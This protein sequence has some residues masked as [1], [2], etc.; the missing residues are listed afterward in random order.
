MQLSLSQRG[1]TTIA[2]TAGAIDDS[3]R[4][5]F[6]E[7]LHPVIAQGSAGLILDLSGSNYVNSQGLGHLVTLGTHANTKGTALVLCGLMPHVAGVVS[8]TKL[9][10][11]F[12]IAPDVEGAL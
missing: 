10:R 2:Q 12:A 1:G 6:R 4:E 11:F 3:A 5:Q 9:D 7:H 8:V